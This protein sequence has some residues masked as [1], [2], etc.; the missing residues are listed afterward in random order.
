MVAISSGATLISIDR[1][2]MVVI[3]YCGWGPLSGLNK[4]KMSTNNDN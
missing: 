4:L 2:K 3:V 1:P